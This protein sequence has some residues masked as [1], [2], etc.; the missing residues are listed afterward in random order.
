[1]NSQAVLLGPDYDDIYM[2]NNAKMTYPKEDYDDEED[3]EKWT[4]KLDF[5]FSCVGYAIGKSSKNINNRR[6]IFNNYVFF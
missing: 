4:N 3:R 5:I 6:R 1:M 2:K